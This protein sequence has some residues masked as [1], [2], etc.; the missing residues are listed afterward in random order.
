MMEE[1][2]G[3]ARICKE[4]GM[5]YSFGASI[6][7]YDTY[8]GARV[9]E[10]ERGSELIGIFPIHIRIEGEKLFFEEWKEATKET[11]RNFAIDLI[12]PRDLFLRPDDVVTGEG[13]AEEADEIEESL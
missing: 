2:K 8:E 12:D 3:W 9:R 11:S 10:V 7:I 4:N 6:F 5:K 13:Y 1:I